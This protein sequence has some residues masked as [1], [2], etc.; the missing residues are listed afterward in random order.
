MVVL[1][2]LLTLTACRP[3]APPPVAA[4]AVDLPVDQRLFTMLIGRYDS[5]AQAAADAVCRQ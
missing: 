5:S 4:P 1:F 2:A 3:A